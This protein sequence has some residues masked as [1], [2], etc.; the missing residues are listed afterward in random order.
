MKIII[1]VVILLVLIYVWRLR[2]KAW[3]QFLDSPLA[4]MEK[5]HV[6]FEDRI[7]TPLIEYLSEDSDEVVS[8]AGGYY[9][10]DEG[11]LRI[12]Y[13]KQVFYGQLTRHVFEWDVSSEEDAEVV[14]DMV[15]DS[16]IDNLKTY[17]DEILDTSDLYE[18]LE[19]EDIE[20]D[21]DDPEWDWGGT[22]L[23]RARQFLFS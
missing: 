20:I 6:Y 21:P 7:T 15:V 23:T 10:I 16:E 19:A 8:L 14:F 11:I 12:H 5:N 9:L 22:H 18:W 4:D 13:F 17:E 3:K 1:G 2:K